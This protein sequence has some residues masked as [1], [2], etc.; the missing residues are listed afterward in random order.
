MVIGHNQQGHHQTMRGH[1]HYATADNEPCITDLDSK[2]SHWDID[3]DKRKTIVTR[4]E[5][6]QR[7]RQ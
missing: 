6:P 2:K 1:E 3:M 7:P 5:N 4:T